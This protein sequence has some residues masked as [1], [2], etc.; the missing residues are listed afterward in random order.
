M[1][2]KILL[3]LLACASLLTSPAFGGP[4]EDRLNKALTT[5]DSLKADFKQTVLDDRNSV[6][7][8]SR[9]TVSIQRPGKFAWIYND[10]YQQKIISDG[11]ELWVYDVDLDQVT[12]K[13]VDQGLATAPIMVL[14]KK[15]GIDQEFNISE[16][17]QHKLLYWV[18]LEPKKQDMEYARIQLG[19]NGESIEAM[20]L[21]DTFGQKTQIVFENLRRDV[22]FDPATF[23]FV[24]PEGVDVFGMGK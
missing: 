3:S 10:P 19:L 18:E 15:G 20:Q 8:H 14:M 22:V 21:V 1:H 7:Q 11:N 6:V 23:K 5:L 17:A 24:P 2:S 13:P 9:G 16:I 12:V 4:L